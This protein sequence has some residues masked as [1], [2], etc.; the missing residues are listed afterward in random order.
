MLRY[1]F[2]IC[3]CL[4]LVKHKYIL[5]SLISFKQWPCWILYEKPLSLVGWKTGTTHY[6]GVEILRNCK[7][8]FWI[9]SLQQCT[10]SFAKECR[11]ADCS[12]YL[13]F[14]AWGR[15]MPTKT[16]EMPLFWP[17]KRLHGNLKLLMTLLLRIRNLCSTL[18]QCSCVSRRGDCSSELCSRWVLLSCSLTWFVAPWFWMVF[19]VQLVDSAG[20]NSE[21]MSSSTLRCQCQTAQPGREWLGMVCVWVISNLKVRYPVG[22]DY[23]VG[24]AFTL[25]ILCIYCSL[26]WPWCATSLE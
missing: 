9:I 25:V 20:Q 10:K 6:L 7:E 14:C 11:V 24:I 17:A 2:L 22:I 19:C 1:F 18:E 3:R 15:L 8:V 26:R 5:C 23:G 4:C 21:R 13:C 12:L 16:H